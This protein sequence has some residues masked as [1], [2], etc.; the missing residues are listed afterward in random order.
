MAVMGGTLELRSAG[1]DTGAVAILTL[2]ADSEQD[3]RIE[4]AA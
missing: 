3:Q 4:L 1:R 2:D